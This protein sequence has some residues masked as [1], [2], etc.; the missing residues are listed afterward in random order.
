MS[1]KAQLMMDYDDGEDGIMLYRKIS[2][3]GT[4]S[5]ISNLTNRDMC[6]DSQLNW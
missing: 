3:V 1:I 6:H 5:D 2:P 4:V